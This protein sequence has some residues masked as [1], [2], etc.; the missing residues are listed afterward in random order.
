MNSSAWWFSARRKFFD[1]PQASGSPLAAEALR[2][3]GEL[4]AFEA[5]MQ[6]KCIEERARRRKYASQPR[7]EARRLWLRQDRKS[8]PDG[9]ALANAIDE[10]R[11]RWAA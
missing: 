4:Y 7:L 5:R 3:I 6:G 9:S 11:R 8:A 10:I 1:V 2:G